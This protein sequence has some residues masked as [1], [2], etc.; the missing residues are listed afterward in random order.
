MYE[1]GELLYEGK[2]KR[3]FA[4]KDHSDKI[5]LSFKDSLTA[6]NALKTGSFADKGKVNLSITEVIFNE[7]HKKDIQTHWVK[8]V[9]DT[10]LVVQKLKMIPL[11]VVVR[12]VLAGSTAKKFDME[13][14]Q[15]LTPPVYELFYKHDALGDP[16]INDSQALFLKTVESQAQLDQIKEL[17]LKVNTALVEIFKSI[18]IKLVDFKIEFGLNPSGE[19]C[20][21]DEISPDSCRLWE[22]GT[23]QVLDKDRFRKDMGQVKESYEEVLNRL[24]NQFSHKGA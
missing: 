12:N 17:G 19:I 3:A 15:D 11:E 24:Q 14:G 6:F 20:L 1:Q 2:A 21:G 10:D 4:V 22:I 5:W 13:A 9:S 18:N 7:L 16:F 23:Q 8:R